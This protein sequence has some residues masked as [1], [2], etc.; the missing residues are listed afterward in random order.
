M[1]HCTKLIES[2]VKGVS[3]RRLADLIA[4]YQIPAPF[5]FINFQDVVVQ[6]AQQV[7]N[8]TQEKAEVLVVEGTCFTCRKPG[9]IARDCVTDVCYT[10][11]VPRTTAATVGSS[12]RIYATQ[13]TDQQLD[14]ASSRSEELWAVS[15]RMTHSAFTTAAVSTSASGIH[16][17]SPQIKVLV[18]TG[19]LLFGSLCSTPSLAIWPSLRH[20]KQVPSTTNT[21]AFS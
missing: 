7:P 13:E 3:N 18:D 1:Y 20:V 4:T 14:R 10:K 12:P 6:F 17:F 2:V 19:N 15:Q 8:I 21:S 16:N 9:H 11:Q 5:S